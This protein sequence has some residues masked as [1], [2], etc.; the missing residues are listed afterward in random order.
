MVKG[1]PSKSIYINTEEF[2]TPK[3]RYIPKTSID[4]YI[5]RVYEMPSVIDVISVPVGASARGASINSRIDVN[6]GDYD[7]QI[8]GWRGCGVSMKYYHIL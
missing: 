2:L 5:T 7:P 4:T 1:V 8:L 6:P 3:F